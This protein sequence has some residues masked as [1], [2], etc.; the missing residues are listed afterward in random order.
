MR[1]LNERVFA[2]GE[3]RVG[4]NCGPVRPRKAREEK[5]ERKEGRQKAPRGITH[6]PRHFPRYSQP[7]YYPPTKRRSSPVRVMFANASERAMVWAACRR[8]ST[9]RRHVR[10]SHLHH[11]HEGA[12]DAREAD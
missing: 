2:G 11:L 4:P 6:L 7:E 3:V 12:A 10:A 1:D 9:R 8:P 5:R